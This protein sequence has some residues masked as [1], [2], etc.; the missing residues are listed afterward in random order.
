MMIMPDME[1]LNKSSISGIFMGFS[2]LSMVTRKMDCML[3]YKDI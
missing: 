2:L 1:G 3:A